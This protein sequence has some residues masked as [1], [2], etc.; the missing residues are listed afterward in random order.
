M[1]EGGISIGLAVVTAAIQSYTAVETA[2]DA[3]LNV[4][5]FPSTYQELRLGLLIERYRLELWANHV[6][7]KEKQE[8]VKL[9]QEYWPLWKI[10]ESIFCLMIKA[11]QDSD[12]SM[13]NYAQN[14]GLPRHD[15]LSGDFHISEFTMETKYTL[16]LQQMS[17]CYKKCH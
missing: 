2:Y 1:A 15:G 3:Y 11:F 14:M 10:F 4:K 5:E 17:N 7:S 8:E 12:Q 16:T 13:E 6:L 9:C